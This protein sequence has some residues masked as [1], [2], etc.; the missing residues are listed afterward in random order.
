MKWRML[1]L[2]LLAALAATIPVAM[3]GCAKEQEEEM[4]VD[5]AITE[6]P[7]AGEVLE[8]VPEAVEETYTNQPAQPGMGELPPPTNEELQNPPVGNDHSRR[9][10][11]PPADE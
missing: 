6:P 10:T 1:T 4:P 5:P 9:E 8:G 11:P 3:I 7:P 2:M